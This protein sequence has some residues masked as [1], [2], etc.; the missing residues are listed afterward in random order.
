MDWVP[1]NLKLLSNPLNW[2]Q[3]WLMLFLG[4]ML[5]DLLRQ[6]HVNV[7]SNPNGS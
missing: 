4:G 7:S 2:V 6:Y 3:I 1:L 5:L